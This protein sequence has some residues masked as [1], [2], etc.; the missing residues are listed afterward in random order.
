MQNLTISKSA[1]TRVKKL[2]R[3]VELS[4]T[5]MYGSFCV[6]LERNVLDNI[7]NDTPATH[8]SEIKNTWRNLK[9]IALENVSS[10]QLADGLI[11]SHHSVFHPILQEALES[12]LMI[13]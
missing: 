12:M 3:R 11:G 5:N 10:G 1:G 4:V 13:P 8:W 2:H 7:A 6:K 9:Y